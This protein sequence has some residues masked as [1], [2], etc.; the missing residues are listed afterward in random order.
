MI[1]PPGAEEPTHPASVPLLLFDDAAGSTRSLN[2]ERLVAGAVRDVLAGR[3]GT[4]ERLD[5]LG[6]MIADELA[7]LRRAVELL[8]ELEALDDRKPGAWSLFLRRLAR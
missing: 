1:H 6:W 5:A 4:P 8:T 7:G 3:P 2:L